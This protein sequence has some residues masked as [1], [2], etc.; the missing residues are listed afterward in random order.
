MHTNPAPD[1]ELAAAARQGDAS[2]LAA[3][4]TAHAPAVMALA[5]RLTGSR[6][7]AEDVLHDVFLGLPE[8][9]RRYGER[10]SFGAWL[11]RVAARTALMRLRRG[12]RRREVGIEAVAQSESTY[13]ADVAVEQTALWRAVDALPDSLRAVFVLREVEGFTHAEVAAVLGITPAASEVR[14]CRALKRLREQLEG[15]R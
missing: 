6:A 1:A 15:D 5:W 11:R 7:D 2:A 3:L 8:A 9:L 13:R 10:G 4:Y 12:R 14:L